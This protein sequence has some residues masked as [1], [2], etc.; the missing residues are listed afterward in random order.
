MKT[1]IIGGTFNP[2]HNGHLHLLHWLVTTTDY[3]RMLF[4]PVYS[5]PHKAYDRKVTDS[6]RI[7][8]LTLGLQA[9]SKEYP[10]DRAV[11]LIVDDC[12]IRRQGVSFMFD[13]VKD[14][15]IRYQV[16]G[17]PAVVIGDDLLP[18]L[19]AWH[20]FDELCG[21]VDFIV[22]KRSS[23]LFPPVLPQKA[24]GCIIQN[25]LVGGSSTEIR[26]ILQA[27]G[28]DSDLASLMPQSVVHYIRY[29]GLYT[30]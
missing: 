24:T 2:V 1:A 23:D 9:Y 28:T 25:P 19:S 20:R 10:H 13:T 12:E 6:D 26:A 21:L 30:D 29:H 14:V 16:E 3:Q 18:G 4:I 17:K 15:L 7:D 5:P 22:F 27:G 8:M 11:E